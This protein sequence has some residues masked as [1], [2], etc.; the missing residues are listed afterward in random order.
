MLCTTG[1]RATIVGLSHTPEIDGGATLTVERRKSVGV[2]P[3]LGQLVQDCAG[4]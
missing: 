4:Q 1:P 3:M 2:E